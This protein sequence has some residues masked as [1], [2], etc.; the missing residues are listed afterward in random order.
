[1]VPFLSHL[2]SNIVSVCMAIL[3]A[4][5]HF[6]MPLPP[7]CVLSVRTP[8]EQQSS[9]T[10]GSVHLLDGESVDIT[11]SSANATKA[12]VDGISESPL[13]GSVSYHPH[14]TTTYT[15][16]FERGTKQVTCAVIVSV[17]QKIVVLTPSTPSV[18]TVPVKVTPTVPKVIPPVVVPPVV[19]PPVNPP[20]KPPTVPLGPTTIVVWNIPLLSGGPIHGSQNV[21]VSYLQI[22]NVGTASTIVTGFWMTQTGT[23]PA[24]TVIGLSTVDDHGGSRGSVGGSEGSS[25]FTSYTALAPSDAHFEPGQLR[26]FTIKAKITG[27]TGSLVG[28]SISLVV[29]KVETAATVEGTFPI[30]GTTYTIAK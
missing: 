3:I 9:T 20:N 17:T 18:L 27:D 19:T 14:A 6:F 2:F 16:F 13:S 24:N 28:T 22:T 4:I 1:M 8:T 7:T 26:L 21:P 12:T 10:E 29:S 23:A 30:R 15:Y 5:T 25:P 11:W